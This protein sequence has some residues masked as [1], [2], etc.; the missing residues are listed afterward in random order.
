ME[1]FDKLKELDIEETSKEGFNKAYEE[2]KKNWKRL[3]K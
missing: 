1:E 3:L 2:Y